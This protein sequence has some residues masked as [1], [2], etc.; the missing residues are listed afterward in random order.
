MYAGLGVDIETGERLNI[1]FGEDSRFPH[2]NGRDMLWNPTNEYA[3]DLWWNTGGIDGDLYIGGKHYIYVFGHN[4]DSTDLKYMP[5]YDYGKYIHDKLLNIVLQNNEKAYTWINAMWVTLPMLSQDMVIQENPSDP[6]YFMKTDCKVSIRIANPYRQGVG[7]FAK[8]TPENNN[9]PLYYFSLKDVAPVIND[10]LT[11]KDALNLIRAV[12][13]PY[14]GYSEYEK[15]Q[16]E[17]L[18]KFTNLPQQCTISIYTVNGTLIRRFRKD[19]PLSYQDWDLKNEYGIPIASGVYI[20]HIDAPGIGEKV[21]KWFGAMRPID[22][23]N[24]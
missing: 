13:N 12:P 4:G 21:I 20:I 23:T 7:E 18:I 9:Y 19:S 11:A 14:Y 17:N 3:S 5:S 10:N 8:P 16:L 24:F 6:Y 2:Q 1:A 22:L 15:S